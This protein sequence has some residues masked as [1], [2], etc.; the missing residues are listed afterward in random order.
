M[1]FIQW[2]D[3][4]CTGIEAVDQQHQHLVQIVNKLEDAHSRKKG[5]RIMNEILNDLIGYTQEHFAFEEKLQKE[6][7]YPRLEQHQNLHRQLLQKIERYQFEFNR[8]GRRIT[9]EVRDFLHRWLTNHILQEDMDFGKYVLS[10]G[11][12][13][14]NETAVETAPEAETERTDTPVTS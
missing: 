14:E 12:S 5:T 2:S 7:G 10:A 1:G 6:S 3:E 9:G 11:A 8:Q 4:L 13:D